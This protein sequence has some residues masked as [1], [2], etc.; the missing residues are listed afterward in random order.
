VDYRNECSDPGHRG[1]SEAEDDYLHFGI[2]WMRL[3]L[4]LERASL[5]KGNG[6]AYYLPGFPVDPEHPWDDVVHA[7]FHDRSSV[8]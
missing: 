6:L 7:E 3:A 8:R 5:A 4:A 1:L 2:S